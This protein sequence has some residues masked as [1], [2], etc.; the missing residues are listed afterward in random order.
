MGY[1]QPGAALGQIVFK[2]IRV[3]NK[4]SEDLT[5]H[6][7]HSGLIQMLVTT[8]MIFMVLILPCMMFAYNGG[9][10][11]GDYAAYGLAPAAVGYDFFAGLL[12]KALVN[13]DL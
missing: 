6:I 10:D 4:R 9:P 11:D 13:S 3:L 12:L 2:N 5:A 7:Y 1:N 8:P